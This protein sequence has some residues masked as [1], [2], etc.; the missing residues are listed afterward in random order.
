[1][2]HAFVVA[3]DVVKELIRDRITKGNLPRH[4]TI[5]LWDGAGLGQI[6][7]GCGQTIGI[8]ERMS[9]ICADDWRAVRFHHACFEVW[10]NE[11]RVG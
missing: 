9:L 5:E 3:P 2:C 11:R 6:C 4:H 10:E 8:N 1:M 7:D